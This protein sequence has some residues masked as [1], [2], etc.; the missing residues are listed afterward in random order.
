MLEVPNYSNL[1]KL[2]TIYRLI[3]LKCHNFYI[4]STIRPLYTKIKEHLKTY[5]HSHSINIQLNA[6]KK[7]MIIFPLK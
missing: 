6:K 4:G 3:W 5:M 1:S 2:K 7:K